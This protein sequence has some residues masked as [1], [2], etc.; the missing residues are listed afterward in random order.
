MLALAVLWMSSVSA[1]ET[2]PRQFNGSYTGRNLDRVAF[3]IGG[4]G[5]GMFCIEGSGAISHV[6]F[7][8]KPEVFNEPAVFAAIC[9]L[10]E[11]G[12]D[13]VAHVVEG[14]IPDWKYFGQPGTGNGGAGTTYGLPR[15]RQ[16]E[17]LARFPFATIRLSDALVPLD[18]ELTAWSPF[19]P[20]DA[21]PSSLPVG[22]IEY[23]FHNHSDRPRRA[24]F[25]FNA[26]NFLGDGPIEAIDGGFILKSP[27]AKKPDGRGAFA[28]FADGEKAVVDH[29][30]F[31][32]GWWDPLTIAW[33][34]VA[35]GVPVD[36]PPVKG[37]APG[38]TLAVPFD[39][40]RAR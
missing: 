5:A 31:R 1:A 25:S 39:S 4:I 30:W 26:R 34:N 2:P 35:R 12:Q 16:A 28:V 24:V 29:C 13:N 14:P 18:V 3:P 23:R 21:D 40:R 27:D 6:S 10:G 36:N 15:F 7:H 8:H 32:G 19:T 17:F 9:V 37:A 22:A 33:R 20:P 11:K 38:A